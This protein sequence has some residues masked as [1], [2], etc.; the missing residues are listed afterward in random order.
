[1]LNPLLYTVENCVLA[2]G[3]A[4]CLDM[5]LDLDFD[6]G[7]KLCISIHGFIDCCDFLFQ[8]SLADLT[9]MGFDQLTL[10]IEK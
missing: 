10:G 3:L 2:F 6:S 9:H 1:M 7:A 5:G 8:Y 4:M